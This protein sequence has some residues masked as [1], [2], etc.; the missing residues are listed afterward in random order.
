MGRVRE[1][2]KV[3]GKKFWTVFDMGARNTYIVPAVAARLVTFK[4]P[5]HEISRPPSSR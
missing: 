2:I 4:L 5:K 1:H 3:D